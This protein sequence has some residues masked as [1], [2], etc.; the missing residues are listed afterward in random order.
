MSVSDQ[1][2][3]WQELSARFLKAMVETP[4]RQLFGGSRPSAQPGESR[5]PEVLRIQPDA[6]RTSLTLWHI[7]GGELE[8][9]DEPD[10][11]LLER[12]QHGGGRL[13]L[14]VAGFSDAD[15]LA[16]VGAVFGLHAVTLADLVNIERQTKVDSLDERSVILLQVLALSQADDRPGLGQLGM[17]LAGDVLLTFR[18]R[19]GPVFDPVL[20]R[21][22]RPT[23]R[24][25]SEPLDYLACALL[26]VAIDASFPVVEHLADRVDAVE[27]SVMAGRGHDLL[28][29]IHQLRRALITLG[30]LFW[31]QRDL[32]ARLL[33]DEEIFRRQTHI[34]LRDIYDRTVQLLDMVETTRELAAS[35]VEIHL[36]ISANRTN[37]IMKT[38]TIMASIFIPLTFIAGVYGMNF[39]R[40]PELAWPWGYPA[41]L[42]LMLAVSGGLLLWFRRRG[43]LG[44]RDGKS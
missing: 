5:G 12:L 11:G 6:A 20:T 43:W 28:G 17:V 38:L 23:S 42:G 24:L 2:Q 22:A 41:V 3:Q 7:A 32:S 25:R 13:W 15:R 36:S 9:F 10:R 39:E 8:R 26:D 27:E 16:A 40:M 18:E 37:Q 34:Y 29:E 31:R 33:R 19:P 1:L 21:L 14:D 44:G 30:R 4:L 35:L